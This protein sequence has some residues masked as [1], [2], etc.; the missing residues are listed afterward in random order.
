[1]FDPETENLLTEFRKV[2]DAA[3]NPNILPEERTKAHQRANE[4]GLQIGER[5][6]E[7]DFMMGKELNQLERQMAKAAGKA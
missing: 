2:R 1:M 7:L 4:L 3:Y 5:S 6:M